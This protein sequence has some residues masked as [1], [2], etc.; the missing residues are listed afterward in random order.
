MDTYAVLNILLLIHLAGLV[1]GFVGGRAHGVVISRI[2]GAGDETAE[3][4]WQFEKSAS[5]TAFAGTALLVFSGLAMLSLKYGG[6]EDQ[7]YF[8]WIKMVLVFVVAIAEI[9]RHITAVKWKAGDAVMQSRSKFWGKVSGI[10]A[11]ATV[12]VAVFNFN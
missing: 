12:I 8:F 2:E 10:S 1:M 4:L 3:M 7:D 6:F 11:I 9:L 5:W